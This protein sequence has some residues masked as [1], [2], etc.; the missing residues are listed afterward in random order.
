MGAGGGRGRRRERLAGGT[1]LG[2]KESGVARTESGSE[3][4]LRT[5]GEIGGN[6]EVGRGTRG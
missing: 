6:R 1:T 3:E 2:V 5:I 4:I